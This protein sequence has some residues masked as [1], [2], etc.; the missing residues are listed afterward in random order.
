M[1]RL[2]ASSLDVQ[3][4]LCMPAWPLPR[5]FQF[6][7]LLIYRESGKLCTY[8]EKDQ[9]WKMHCSDQV[10]MPD[11][12]TKTCTLWFHLCKISC[13]GAVQSVSGGGPTI[14]RTS[15]RNSISKCFKSSVYKGRCSAA[16]HAT[17][18]TTAWNNLK[19]CDIDVRFSHKTD[20]FAWKALAAACK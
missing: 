12:M 15:R 9:Y 7:T 11:L 5:G 13:Q 8:A 10:R 14:W 16:K 2:Y 1:K 17:D 3:V 4:Y 6:N 18:V 20:R 19:R